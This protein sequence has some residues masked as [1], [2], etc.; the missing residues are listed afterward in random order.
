MIDPTEA[1]VFDYDGVLGDT[2]PLHWRSWAALLARYGIELGWDEYCRVGQGV[3]DVALFAHFGAQMSPEAAREF[4]SLNHERK[5][6]VRE[7]SLAESPISGVTVQLLHSLG[8]R[9]VGMVTSSERADVEPVLRAA[10]IYPVFGALVFGEEPAA[11]KPSPAPYLLI[12]QRLNINS[13]IAFED[14]EPGLASA[15]AAGFNAV[16]I[17]RPSDLANI[18]ASLLR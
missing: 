10:Q 11:P 18:V 2:E 6:M 3:N 4:E 9:R 15:R 14:S 17:P 7:W 16:K 13:G 5:R 12:A 8:G 1:L